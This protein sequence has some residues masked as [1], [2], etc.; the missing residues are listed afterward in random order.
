VL[1][2][3]VA[4]SLLW[5]TPAAAAEDTPA[6][7]RAAAEALVATVN[8]QM[9]IDKVMG[10]MQEMM[11][12]QMLQL[13][14]RNERLTPAQQERAAQVLGREMSAAMT[15][16]MASIMPAVNAATIDLYVE[17]FTLA[18][19]AELQRFYKSPL[20][21]K[22]FAIM[23]DLPKLMQPMMQALQDAQPVIA[24]RIE[25]AIERLR[26][27]GIDLSPPRGPPR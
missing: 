21:T 9:G 7:R 2:G 10:N 19:L 4:A 23:D 3:L 1:C 20:G 25:A 8:Q 11:Q 24:Q 13:V 26:L 14:Q 17:R 27:E 16:T 12:G 6:A 5:T 22:A 15:D 18:E